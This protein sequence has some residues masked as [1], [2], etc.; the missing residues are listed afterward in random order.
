MFFDALLALGFT[1]GSEDDLDGMYGEG[2]GDVSDVGA[3]DGKIEENGDGEVEGDDVG[4]TLGIEV[5]ISEGD[6]E[7]LDV[8]VTVGTTDGM[9]DG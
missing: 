1:D 8:K 3:K 6:D 4:V 9:A 7:G 5:G 2:D